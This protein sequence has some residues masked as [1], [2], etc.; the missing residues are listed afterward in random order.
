MLY[1]AIS[2]N[3]IILDHLGYLSDLIGSPRD[4]N[5]P[6]SNLMSPPCDLIGP[7]R[8]LNR[9]LN[10]SQYWPL[11]APPG[12]FSTGVTDPQTDGRTDGPTEG[13]TLL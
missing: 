13:H 8:D 7:Q 12:D 6:Q 5:R 2:S 4:L 10:K 9:S 1:E 3:V 11:D